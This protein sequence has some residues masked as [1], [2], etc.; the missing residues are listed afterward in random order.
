M[1]AFLNFYSGFSYLKVTTRVGHYDWKRK[2]QSK[3]GFESSEPS[4]CMDGIAEV[5]G[6]LETEKGNGGMNDVTKEVSDAT[7]EAVKEGTCE[8]NQGVEVRA[9][10]CCWIF[11]VLLNKSFL[12]PC[13]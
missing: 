5:G 7:V 2:Y 10:I 4:G 1:H 11:L 6:D 12:L 8:N 13:Q 9:N 3:N